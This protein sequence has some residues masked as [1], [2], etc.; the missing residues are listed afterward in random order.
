MSDA[1]FAEGS[2][3]RM[4]QSTH[5]LLA[6]TE[7]VVSEYYQ[8]EGAELAIYYG[9]VNGGY[10]NVMVPAEAVELVMTVEQMQARKLP[11]VDGFTRV[12]GSA[13]CGL[14]DLDEEAMRR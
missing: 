9:N 5:D 7:F 3:V 4:T 11:T 13:L 10:N 14:D 2:K 12:I 1:I 6:G 8:A